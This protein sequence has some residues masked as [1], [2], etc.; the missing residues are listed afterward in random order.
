[1]NAYKITVHLNLKGTIV[2]D[3]DYS[4]DAD[5]AFKAIEAIMK[6]INLVLPDGKYV[7]T[8]DHTNTI[9]I[10]VTIESEEEK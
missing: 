7:F 3:L 9:E 5:S 4:R 10:S 2:S 6:D 1:M 8:V